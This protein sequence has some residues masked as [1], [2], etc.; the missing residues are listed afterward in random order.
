MNNIQYK[1]FVQ[2]IFSINQQNVFVL[3][4]IFV[5]LLFLS[6][7]STLLSILRMLGM[8]EKPITC[9]KEEIF[10]NRHLGRFSTELFN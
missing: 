5:F 1:A 4:F 2:T 9:T 6:S 7:S 10:Q 3:F 8:K